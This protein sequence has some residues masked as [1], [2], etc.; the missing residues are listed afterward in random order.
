MGTNVSTVIKHNK[1]IRFATFVRNKAM[2]DGHNVHDNFV[3]NGFTKIVTSTFKQ[4]TI[5]FH[6]TMK[7]FITVHFADVF[8]REG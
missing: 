1:Q 8:K 5:Y 2:A 4:E 6:Q 3:E 7:K